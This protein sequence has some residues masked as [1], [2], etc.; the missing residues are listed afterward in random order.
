MFG[1][2][3][4]KLP[5]ANANINYTVDEITVTSLT[6]NQLVYSN[7]YDLLVSGTIIG[8]VDQITVTPGTPNI[9][10]SFPSVLHSQNNVLDD[11][12]GIATFVNI[13]DSGLTASEA[14][15]TNASK[16]LSSLA[17]TSSDTA[18][19]LVERDASGNFS[20]GTITAS[21]IGGAS[22]DLPLTGGTM[23]GNLIL[24][25][26]ATLS[27]Q[28]V[29]YEQLMAVS[30]GIDVKAACYAATTGT[31]L[32][33]TYNNGVSGVG[34]TLTGVSTGVFTIDGVSP[35]VGSRILVKDET[36]TYQNG[37]YV[38]TTSAVGFLAVL[39]R[40]SDYNTIADIQAGD[41]I[42]VDNGTINTGTAW[43]QT[44]TVSAIGAGNPI[45]FSPFGLT[46]AGT[47]LTKTGNTISLTNPVPL[48]LGGTNAALT[49]VTDGVVYSTSSA[50]AILSTANNAVLSTNGSGVPS[51]STSGTF[52]A[53]MITSA[54]T[55]TVTG[56][57]SLDLAIANN[58]SDVASA[59][60]SATNLGLG[61]GN[62]PSFTNLT[63][64]GLTASE[65]VLTNSSKE[66]IS[67]QINLASSSYVTGLLP[68][69]NG[70]TNASLTASNGGIFYSTASAGAI[71]G[72]T[73]TAG[74][75]LTSGAS[76]APAWT[77]STYPATNAV[78]T[79]LYAS[80]ANA[81]AALATA[82]NGALITSSGGVPS[83]SSTLPSAVQGNI[84]ALG[85][86]TSLTVLGT[87]NIN[88]SGSAVTTLGSATAVVDINGATT[89]GST[90]TL[91]ANATSALQ[92]VTYQQLQA[93]NT[94]DSFTTHTYC[95]GF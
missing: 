25:A 12:T 73:A 95:G 79:L 3:A 15:V 80:S 41:L 76:S 9:T 35:A 72:G 14:V 62:S 5:T 13:I 43:L 89:F 66:L 74:Q 60:T 24:N 57:S 17:Y 2:F 84:T 61:T 71:L 11:G 68:L 27:L 46:F 10:L 34:A 90:V 47:G 20:A 37:I 53:T 30:A 31:D 18:S 93:S 50:L 29:T 4:P 42:V 78:N 33:Y 63:L 52:S 69:A 65:P 85:T 19:T 45:L 16:Q 21:L 23:T 32:G 51:M 7:G 81:M 55:G 75:L 44:A 49:A 70:G 88:V 54:L 86:L 82:N 92:A 77:T 22:L 26:D 36:A 8:T 56:H 39:T 59:T 1:D 94:P 58:L 64:T 67:G 87:S 40:S 91:N 28:A 38:V 6:P 83:I 48:N